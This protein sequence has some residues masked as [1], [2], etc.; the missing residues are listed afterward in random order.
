MAGLKPLIRFS[1]FLEQ[2]VSINIHR[3]VRANTHSVRPAEADIK[4]IIAPKE[5]YDSINQLSDF[6]V[7]L[8]CLRGLGAL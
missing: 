1:V 4:K 6:F 2:V 3:R 8:L 7:R 5:A